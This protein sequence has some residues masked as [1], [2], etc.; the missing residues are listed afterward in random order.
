ME[1]AE[2]DEVGGGDD[3]D[4]EDRTVKRSPRSKNL[5]RAT[6]Y[7]TRDARQAFTQ[8]RQMFTKVLILWHFNP[9]C[10]IRIE[11]DV[12]GYAIDSVLSQLT[13]LGQWHPMAYYFRK[14]IPAKTRYKTHNSEL[15][16]IV[17]VFKIWRH[18]LESC[19]HEV[20]M[21]TNHNNLCRFMKT[22]NLSF[23]QV[24][25]AQE[26][27]QY[28]FQINYYQGKANGAVYTLS[29]F[30]QKSDDK[31]EKLLAENSQILHWL[32]FLLTNASLSG[33]AF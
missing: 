15:L 14:M 26:L 6:D 12:L 2:S 31:E 10:H 7:L 20:L 33:L 11:T 17:E 22:K 28:H 27:L 16:A 18:Y 30:P 23:H 3:G 9:E 32:Q 29:R 1:V 25:W 4:C 8:L 21:L 19:K 24:W 5:N 13:N